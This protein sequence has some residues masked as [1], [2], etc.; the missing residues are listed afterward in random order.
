MTPI[1]C[2]GR[3][4]GKR[5]DRKVLCMYGGLASSSVVCR[6]VN[7]PHTMYPAR[8]WNVRISDLL[9]L[10]IWGRRVCIFSRRESV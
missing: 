1:Q 4:L 2:E 9:G 7:A 6:E 5:C 8:C 10:G 3:N